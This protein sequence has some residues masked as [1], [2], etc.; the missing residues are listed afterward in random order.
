MNK[1]II[2]MSFF[3]GFFT[4]GAKTGVDF[5]VLFRKNPFFNFVYIITAVFPGAVTA[6]KAVGFHIY[7]IITIIAFGPMRIIIIGV[8]SEI[9]VFGYGFSAFAFKSMCIFRYRFISANAFMYMDKFKPDV[10]VF[11]KFKNGSVTIRNSDKG[12]VAFGD[13]VSIRRFKNDF[14]LFIVNRIGVEIQSVFNR[15]GNKNFALSV[16]IN[17][18]IHSLCEN[19]SRHGQF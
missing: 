10:A 12:N 2:V 7:S 16:G 15:A 13:G 19:I 3:K 9:A 6:F 1:F 14:F 18:V 5:R 11:P 8:P 17:S 4:F